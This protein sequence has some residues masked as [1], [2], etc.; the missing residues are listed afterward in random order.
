MLPHL[1]F[2]HPQICSKITIDCILATASTEAKGFGAQECKILFAWQ[3]Y[4][5]DIKQPPKGYTNHIYV[6]FRFN[7][8]WEGHISRLNQ[9]LKVKQS[10]SV[11]HVWKKKAA[12]NCANQFGLFMSL[13]FLKKKTDLSQVI[14]KAEED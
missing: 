2:F 8:Q 12:Y 14:F 11:L 6:I 13:L 3:V 10:L 1:Q 5:P 4:C 7:S 9:V